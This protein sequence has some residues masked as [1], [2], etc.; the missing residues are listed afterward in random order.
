MDDPAV[1]EWLDRQEAAVHDIRHQIEFAKDYES[2]GVKMPQ[3]MSIN[4]I[5]E[6]ILPIM[7]TRGITFVF[8]DKDIEVYA[9]RCLNSCFTTWW[10]IPSGTV[11]A[12]M[13]SA[14]S[15]CRPV[16]AWPSYIFE[17]WCRGSRKQ[18]T[19]YL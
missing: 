3:W 2:L 14:Y 12:S 4:R 5:F 16:T 9:D 1:L 7:G 18:Q 13:P 11:N 6:Q 10:T 8:P 19:E 17:Q 15:T